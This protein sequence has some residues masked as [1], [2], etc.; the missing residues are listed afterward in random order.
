MA[1]TSLDDV[2]EKERTRLNEMR[3]EAQTRKAVIDEEI[4]DID[5]QLSYIAAY[6]NAKAGK[7][8]STTQRA[9]RS[10]GR[11]ATLLQFINSQQDGVTRSDI[12]THL[13]VKGDK[14]QEQSVSNA[15]SVLKKT[16]KIGQQ[17]GR[18]MVA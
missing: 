10:D 5:R 7:K 18:Y 6:D 11:R 12:L 17:N 14:A 1:K 8:K 4:A 9:P 2:M 13:G 16:G 15:L 3:A